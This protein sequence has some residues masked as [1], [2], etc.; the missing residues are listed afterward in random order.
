MKPRAAGK[1]ILVEA[2][3]FRIGCG[4]VTQAGGN[5]AGQFV[6]KSPLGTDEERLDWM[7]QLSAVVSRARGRATLMGM[8]AMAAAALLFP[9]TTPAQTVDEIIAKNIQAHGGMEKIKAV[10]TQRSTGKILFG[11][12]QA[13]VVQINKRPDKV[14]EEASLQGFTQIQVYDGKGAWQ[15]NPFGGRK[16][17]QLMSEDDAKSLVVDADIDRPLV[18]YKQKGHK[19][20]LV[21]HDSVEGTDCYKIK[22]TLKDG[23]IFTYYLDTD[24]FLELKL[25][26]KMTIRGAI[27]EQE[28]YY[29]DYEEVNGMYFPFSLESAQKG[30]PNR[31]KTTIEKMEI[32]IPVND[33]VFVMPTAKPA[34]AK[35]GSASR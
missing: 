14:R 12:I 21:G 26:T 2:F 1:S 28:T 17:P 20:E 7:K 25:E 13:T 15:I 19:A 18:D 29:G 32:N 35:A 11:S 34:A 30:D 10:E 8:M 22:L 24:S 9:A 31:T 23:D 27:Q 6:S 16:D 5:F 33:T 3:Q 4:V